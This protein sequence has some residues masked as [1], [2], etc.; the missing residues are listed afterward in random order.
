MMT[1]TSTYIY[2]WSTGNKVSWLNKFYCFLFFI[3]IV[4]RTMIVN[5]K[6]EMELVCVD[7][8]LMVE[9]YWAFLGR[10]FVRSA[11]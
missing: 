8:Y 3:P 6:K 5:K 10:W 11:T 9:C 4:R 1:T 7:V 2:I